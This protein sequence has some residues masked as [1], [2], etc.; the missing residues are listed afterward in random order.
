MS[1]IPIHSAL[2]QFARA[3]QSSRDPYE[4]GHGARVSQLAVN[5]A[6]NLRLPHAFC[7]TLAFA[8]SVHDIG[9]IAI[10]EA[11]INKTDKLTDS[12]MDMIQG[13]TLHGDAI[14]SRLRFLDPQVH[15][16]VRHH[17]ENW[18]GSGYPDHLA[19]LDIPEGARI[20]HVVDDFEGITSERPYHEGRTTHDALAIMRLNGGSYEPDI[21]EA[22][23]A[24]IEEGVS[25]ER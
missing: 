23:V 7:E 14:L 2:T 6:M 15:L 19:G 21:F 17:H 25:Y 9:K 12:E 13:H 16:I 8:A 5:L 22:F 1:D 10:A 20:L 24:M 18:D 4:D 11:I 3:I